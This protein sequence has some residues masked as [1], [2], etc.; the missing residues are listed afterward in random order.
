MTYFCHCP[1]YT[2]SDIEEKMMEHK[3]KRLENE[4]VVLEEYRQKILIS[5]SDSKSEVISLKISL[6][7]SD[8]KNLLSSR[9]FSKV[10]ISA[11]NSATAM[12][13]PT[14]FISS[15]PMRKAS[16]VENP[17]SFFNSSC[18]PVMC[19][20]I[21]TSFKTGDKILYLIQDVAKLK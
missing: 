2:P 3:R 9:N 7:I 17:Y 10:G 18:K 6:E 16:L 15:A 19:F 13:I 12:L 8:V 14:F 20:I 5:L 1:F 21:K 11:T 4:L